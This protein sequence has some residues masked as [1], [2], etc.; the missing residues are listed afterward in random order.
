M[1]MVKEKGKPA[2]WQDE[3]TEEQRTEKPRKGKKK[4]ESD[5]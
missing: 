2:Y 3:P 1:P 5:E 4:K